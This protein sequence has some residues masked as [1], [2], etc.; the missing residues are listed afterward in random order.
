VKELVEAKADLNARD[1]VSTHKLARPAKHEPPEG[2][3]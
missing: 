2:R 3:V 1:K